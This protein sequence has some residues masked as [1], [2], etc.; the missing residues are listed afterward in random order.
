MIRTIGFGGVYWGPIVGNY[1]LAAVC[2]SCPTTLNPKPQYLANFQLSCLALPLPGT[3]H[4]G[5]FQLPNQPK[6][7]MTTE[8]KKK[9]LNQKQ[10]LT[11]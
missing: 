9:Q 3:R 8:P 11:P 4:L 2:Y 10:M 1:Y 6:H 7:P 5:V